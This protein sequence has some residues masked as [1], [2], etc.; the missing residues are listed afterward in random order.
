MTQDL[1]YVSTRKGLMMYERNGAGWKLG[2]IAFRGQPVTMALPSKDGRT[3]FAALNLGH[4]GVKLHRTDDAGKTWTEL[5]PPRFPKQP[6]SPKFPPDPNDPPPTPSSEPKGP[7]VSAIWA[8]AWGGP[9][10]HVWAGTTPGGL[11]H[12][13]DNGVTWRLVESLWDNPE[14]LR[15]MGGGTVEPALH[16]ISVDPRD[17]NRVAVAVSCGGVWRTS[18][19]GKTWTIGSNGMINDYMPP[20]LQ[21]DPVTQDPHLVVQSP[22]SP[23]VFW[24]QHHNGIFHCADDLKTWKRIVG[25]PVSSFGFAVAV[26][27]RDGNTAWF[28]PA[29]KDQTRMPVDGKIVVNRTRDGGKTF[30]VLRKGLPQ[31]NAYDLVWR[32]GLAVNRD[33]TLLAMGSSTGGLWV[34]DNEGDAWTNLSAHLPPIHAVCFA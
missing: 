23:E 24:C 11:F 29:D 6:P 31:E 10:G 8:M 17:H 20:N 16:S 13:T 25:A 5:Q 14:R 30:D 19:S 32:H 33:G 4:F 27:P 12:T 34:S 18:D 22:S 26:H 3:V 7:S 2:D 15:W 9:A 1:L 21:G 28:V